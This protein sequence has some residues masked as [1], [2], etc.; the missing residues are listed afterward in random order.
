VVVRWTEAGPAM[1]TPT[2]IIPLLV[3]VCTAAGVGG[4]RLLTAPSLARD[5]ADVAPGAD[6]RTS[7][8]VVEGVK[9]VDTAER[10]ARQLEGLAGVQR[11][12]A[13]ASRAR[14]EVTYDPALTGA[15]AIRDALE[16]PVH[17]PSTGEYLFG[18]YT[19]IEMDGLKIESQ[20]R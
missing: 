10:A 4:S 17:D 5:Y 8:F 6:S 11:L 7:V 20:E 3:V 12:E 14:L 16:A 2:W 15:T 18:L 19:V 1:K 13:F 9:C